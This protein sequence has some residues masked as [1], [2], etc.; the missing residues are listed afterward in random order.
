MNKPLA[1]ADEVITLLP[2]SKLKNSE[3]PIAK[4][5]IPKKN[6]FSKCRGEQYFPERL[7]VPYDS[8]VRLL[9]KPF[10]IDNFVG[11]WS[12]VKGLALKRSNH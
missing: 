12:C 6:L 8:N 3:A 7:S 11:H 2:M 10:R 9:D 1:T 4:P 5:W